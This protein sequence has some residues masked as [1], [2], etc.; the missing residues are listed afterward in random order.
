MS[1]DVRG[2]LLLSSFF[3]LLVLSFLAAAPA[4]NAVQTGGSISLYPTDWGRLETGDLVD[5]VIAVNNTSSDTPASDFPSDGVAPVPAK[6]SG[7]VT[8]FLALDGPEC[9]DHVPGKLR[10]VPVGGSGCVDKDAGVTSCT[11][12]GT[13]SVVVALK[14]SG[15]TLPGG[16]SVDIA[17]IRIEVLDAEGL[18]LLGLKAKS[19]LAGLRACSS[20]AP[21]VCSECEAKGCSTLAFAPQGSVIG[22]PHACPARIIYRG[23]MA[24]PDFFEF[25]GLIT[26]TPPISPT[27]QPFTLSLSNASFNP[28]FSFTLPPGSITAQGTEAYTYRNNNARQTGGIAFLKLAKRDGQPNTF[29]I[30]IQAFDAGLESKATLPLMTVRFM[31]GAEPFETTN[32]WIQKPNGWVMNLPQ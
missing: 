23:D 24:T 17:T 21:S 19:D 28:I 26:L 13:D 30:D 1:T 11:A 18:T 20:S 4:A 6:L 27:T 32:T 8:V 9:T 14:P 3:L 5:V 22:C 29:K 25:H 10:F 12:G 2:S 31:I 15:I 16:G 7:S